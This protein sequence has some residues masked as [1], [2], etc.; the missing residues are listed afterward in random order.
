MYICTYIYIYIYIYKCMYIYMHIFMCID[1]Y[2]YFVP[3]PMDV[4]RISLYVSV[5]KTLS[6]P[7]SCLFFRLSMSPVIVVKSCNR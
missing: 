7:L 2:I 1:L 3:H 4:H 5:K 6:P